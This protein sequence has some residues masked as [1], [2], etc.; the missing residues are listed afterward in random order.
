MEPKVRE[1]ICWWLEVLR[2][3][4]L[5]GFVPHVFSP[6]FAERESRRVYGKFGVE[7][8]VFRGRYAEQ[9]MLHSQGIPLEVITNTSGSVYHYKDCGKYLIETQEGTRIQLL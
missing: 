9:R 6:L 7:M 3:H 4:T 2:K 8:A 5:R 1:S